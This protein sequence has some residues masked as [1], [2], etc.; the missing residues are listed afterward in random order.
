MRLQKKR[1]RNRGGFT[2]IEL[3]I[4]VALI[5]TI[6]AIAIPNFMTYQARSRRSEAYANVAGI[7]RAYK[8]YQADHGTYPD[9]VTETSAQGAA[10]AS[11]PD[12]A[13]H[14]MTAPGTVKMPWD[15]A[16]DNFFK[17]VGYQAEGAVYYTYDVKSASCGNACSEQTCFTITAHGDV[18]GNGALG[19][20]MYVHPMTDAS[21]AATAECNSGIGNF[22]PPVRAGTGEPVYDEVAIRLSSDPY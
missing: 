21:G 2:L 17:I 1:S 14:G 18:D 11:L 8:S 13:A 20:L 6:A 22:P 5:G 16:T 12:P 10:A 4:T 3:M 15:T 7:A 19:A 9:M